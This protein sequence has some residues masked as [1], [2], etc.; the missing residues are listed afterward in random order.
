MRESPYLKSIP[1]HLPWVLGLGVV[2]GVIGPFGSYESAGLGTRFS[3][4]S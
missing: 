4:S 1:R 2:M 3:I